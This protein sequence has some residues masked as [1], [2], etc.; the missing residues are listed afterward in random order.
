MLWLK[1]YNNFKW[2]VFSMN[3]FLIIQILELSEKY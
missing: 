3:I 1:E 2:S